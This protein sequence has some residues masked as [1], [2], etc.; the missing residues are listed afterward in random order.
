MTCVYTCEP[1]I[2]DLKRTNKACPHGYISLIIVLTVK[3]GHGVQLACNNGEILWNYD[4]DAFGNERQIA[5]QD[6]SLDNNPFR[7]SGEYFDKETGTIYLRA[8]NYDPEI[9][10]MLSEDSYWNASNMI[11]G[12]AESPNI[13]AIAQSGD[14][15]VY[16]MNNPLMYDDPS[17]NYSTTVSKNYTGVFVVASLVVVKIRYDCEKTINK[18]GSTVDSTVNSVKEKIYNTKEKKSSGSGKTEAGIH[19]RRLNRQ[20]RLMG[21]IIREVLIQ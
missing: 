19:Q 7:Y 2:R 17:G 1:H 15:Y 9:G 20:A 11:N 16:S 5:G 8:R 6:T 13:N 12:N 3:N 10:R 14:L 4:Y 21:I 18:I